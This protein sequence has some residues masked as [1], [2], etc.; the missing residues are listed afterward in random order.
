METL[1]VICLL[2]VIALLL[3]DK[4][5]IK[6]TE[7]DK[8]E[9]K[10]NTKLPEIMGRAR[11]VRSHEVPNTAIEGQ[12]VRY[13]KEADNFDLEI[14]RE[15]FDLQIPQ[16]EPEE[17]LESVPD[18]EQEEEQWRRER[19]P[20]G[21][22]GFATG[23]TFEELSTVGMLFRQ[24]IPEPSLE[25]ETLAIVQKIQGTELFS[26]LENSMGDASRKIAMLLDRRLHSTETDSG[27]SI[28]RKNTLDDF[29]INAFL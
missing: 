26:L 1:I 24:K 6:K 2:V 25:K 7:K 21:E 10:I 27:S 12:P 5:I 18:F 14:E 13:E 20:I 28:M 17:V 19:E 11:P 22:D 29:D 4:I 9:K 16:E 15:N 8:P 3:Q 23:V